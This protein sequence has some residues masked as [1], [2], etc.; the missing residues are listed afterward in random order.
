MHHSPDGS[1]YRVSFHENHGAG[2]MLL[3][4]GAKR[5]MQRTVGAAH[6]H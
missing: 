5:S 4:T 3:D 6:N 1:G 2:N